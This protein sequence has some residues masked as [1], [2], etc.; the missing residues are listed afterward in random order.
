MYNL[1]V[2]NF[3]QDIT[4]EDSLGYSLSGSSEELSQRREGGARRYKSFLLKKQKTTAIKGVKHQ[5]ITANHKNHISQVNDISAFLC[6]GRCK[7]LGSLR[8]FL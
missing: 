4:E 6:M 1:N 7:S 3:I 5:N 8:L 2:E